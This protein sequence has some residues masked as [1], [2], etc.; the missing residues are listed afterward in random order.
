MAEAPVRKTQKRKR[1][2]GNDKIAPAVNGDA[3]DTDTADPVQPPT[4]EPSVEPME[5]E[6]QVF[7][8]I[9][10]TAEIGFERGTSAEAQPRDLSA[11]TTYI[12]GDAEITSLDW[13][14]EDSDILF[15][16]GSN[17][18][19]MRVM[20]RDSPVS[21]S[22]I[23][24]TPIDMGRNVFEVGQFTW[25][26]S[27][28]AVIVTSE[29]A[30]NYSPLLPVQNTLRRVP[31][32]GK[33]PKIFAKVIGTIT[34]LEYER[35]SKQLVCLSLKGDQTF[36]HIWDLATEEC[37][38]ITRKT[39]EPGDVLLDAA[40]LGSKQFITCGEGHIKRFSDTGSG[41]FDF[42]EL[43]S[44]AEEKDMSGFKIRVE[45]LHRRML[46]VLCADQRTKMMSATGGTKLDPIK[47]SPK[48]SR[49]HDGDADVIDLA[50]EPRT[51]RSN[52]GYTGRRRF[53][54]A[55]NDGSIELWSSRLGEG[56]NMPEHQADILRTFT[57][58]HLS[59]IGAMAFSPDGSYL[60]AAS[61]STVIIWS[62]L[63]IP[64]WIPPSYQNGDAAHAAKS[65]VP[66]FA[67]WKWRVDDEDQQD[68]WRPDPSGDEHLEWMHTLKWSSNDD[69]DEG[70][71]GRLAYGLN[72]RVAIIDPKV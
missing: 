9:I 46:L 30:D 72:T 13:D 48:P 44:N 31:Q 66:P 17:Q 11:D 16:G 7:S 28:E 61:F 27:H 49:T 69:G 3:N 39:L 42:I 59:T 19:E 52:T 50:F 8:P 23:P 62:L 20:P 57:H 43:A 1:K 32:F 41:D 37:A 68:G 36:V 65:A 4:H 29:H 71:N 64:D 45:P 25:I 70:R 40:W 2:S 22:L 33:T 5:I 51:S 38:L 55:Y 15:I 67:I 35:T 21:D 47:L 58:P 63:S 26:D 56:E 18:A 34:A 54:I 12:R 10:T 24:S 60:A 14:P 6:Q 53:A